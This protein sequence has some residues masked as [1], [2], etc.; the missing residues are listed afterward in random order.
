LIFSAAPALAGG[1]EWK[2][3]DPSELALK[4]PTVEKDADAEALFREVRVEDK[5]EYQGDLVFQHYLRIKVFTERGRESQ[6]KIDIPFGKFFGSNIKIKDIAGRT[7]KPDGTIIELKKE[8]VFERT[9]VR[10]SGL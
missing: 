9:V 5:N 3:I 7:I 10:A 1:D 6:S 8:D 4:T 2:P